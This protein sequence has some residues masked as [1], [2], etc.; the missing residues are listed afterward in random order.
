[1]GQQ[2]HEAQ[3]GALLVSE[4]RSAEDVRLTHHLRATRPNLVHGPGVGLDD[5]VGA[6]HH[7]LP[8]DLADGVMLRAE[9]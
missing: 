5:L 1:M 8:V 7:G 9:H 2:A 6:L 4:R 3:R